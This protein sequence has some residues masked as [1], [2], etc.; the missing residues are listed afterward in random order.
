MKRFLAIIAF[1]ICCLC[2]YAYGGTDPIA[3]VS[4]AGHKYKPGDKI[5]QRFTLWYNLSDI[6][7]D[8]EYLDNAAQM[9][10][11]RRY[12]AKSP[13]IDS[14]TIHSYSSPEGPLANNAKL[15]GK[16]ADAARQFILEHANQEI[17]INSIPVAENWEGLI[18][19]IEANYTRYDKDK[20]LSILRDSTINDDLREAR[21]KEFRTS[22]EHILKNHMPR[23]R[24]A[25][26]VCVWVVPEPDPEP[27]RVTIITPP[28]LEEPTDTLEAP[29]SGIKELPPPPPPVV[30][31]IVVTDTARWTFALKTNLLYDAVTA[32][33]ASI[34]FPIGKRFSI[35]AEDTFPWWN[36]GPNG[37]KYCFQLWEMGLEPR[38]WFL[39][40]DEVLQGHFVGIYGKSA[41]YDFQHN[42]DLCYQGEYWSA[43]LSYGYAIPIGKR[44]NMEFSLS[45]GYVRSH[46]RHYQPDPDY[47]HLYIDKYKTGTFSYF[48]P[49]KLAV[50]LVW[51]IEFQWEKKNKDK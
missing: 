19:D 39:P 20:I 51:P 42:F 6:N 22:Y 47:E 24:M 36:W 21:L 40:G 18:E 27:E 12:L 44:L 46:Y 4:G 1:A 25:T 45:V 37:N 31:T 14:I 9:D 50:S 30:D 23:L 32:L 35:M 17:V 15:A 5:Q 7:I 34:E 48:G 8:P 38:W 49:T 33:N 41:K 10:T 29:Q 26:W 2:S 3:T 16:R 28:Q 13:Q 43:G 11:I